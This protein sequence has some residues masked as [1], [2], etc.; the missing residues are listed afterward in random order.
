MKLFQITKEST[1]S[2]A[3]FADVTNSRELVDSMQCGKLQPEVA[4]LNAQLITESLKRCGISDE[5][6]YILAARFNASHDEMKDVEKLINGKEIDLA[7]LEARADQPQ[8]LKHYKIP[9]QELAISSLSEAI[10]CRISARDA[11]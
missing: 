6:N 4:L 8:I 7:D 5:T 3:L 11:L 10:T 9:A 2:L 1:L